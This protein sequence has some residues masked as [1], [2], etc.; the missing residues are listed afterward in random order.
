MTTKIGLHVQTDRSN[1]DPIPDSNFPFLIPHGR[2][3]ILSASKFNPP[4]VNGMLMEMVLENV[5]VS[6]FWTGLRITLRVFAREQQG[7]ARKLWMSR[8][9]LSRVMWKGRWLELTRAVSLDVPAISACEKVLAT[10]DVWAVRL[11]APVIAV[12]LPVTLPLGWD[13]GPRRGA[14]KLR[15]LTATGCA[16]RA[17]LLIRPVGAVP[18]AVAAVNFPHTLPSVV[19]AELRGAAGGGRAAVLVAVVEA[20]VVAVALPRKRNAPAWCAGELEVLA[21]L[22]LAEISLIRAFK[23]R[24]KNEKTTRM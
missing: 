20:V 24:K 17:L 5:F 23:E 1:Q 3:P 9:K 12:R 15:R 19:A 8:W 4:P 18:V 14:R 10:G 13:T 11:V 7:H 22:F 2:S 6:I 21:G 16:G